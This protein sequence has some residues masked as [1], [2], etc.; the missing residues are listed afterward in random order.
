MNNFENALEELSITINNQERKAIKQNL[1]ENKTNILNISNLRKIKN[2]QKNQQT[3]I[4]NKT[5]NLIVFLRD[6]SNYLVKSK[7]E[8]FLIKTSNHKEKIQLKTLFENEIASFEGS[9]SLKDALAILKK[10]G[11]N[12]SEDDLIIFK[13]FYCNEEKNTVNIENFLIDLWEVKPELANIG[14]FK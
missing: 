14:K 10:I 9:S 5:S 8:L 7:N 12:F 2:L 11:I 3:L 1:E 13:E 6:I 4:V